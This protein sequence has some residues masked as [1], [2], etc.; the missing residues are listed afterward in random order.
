MSA[1]FETRTLWSWATRPWTR[2]D[3]TTFQRRTSVEG[4]ASDALGCDATDQEQGQQVDGAGHG[5]PVPPAW[6]DGLATSCQGAGCQAGLRVR[7][8][9]NRRIRRRVLL[10]RVRRALRPREVA[11]LLAE[12]ADQERATR[13]VPN[14]Q[15][16]TGG[17][18]RDK[19]MGA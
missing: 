7:E 10:A 16:D 19:D 18:G 4:D 8:I 15:A 3:K 14:R 12:Q 1:L 5:P 2:C 13:L 6:G 17:M 9:E 11:G